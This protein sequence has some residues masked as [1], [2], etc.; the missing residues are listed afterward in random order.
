[1]NF[2][3]PATVPSL[4]RNGN[5]RLRAWQIKKTQILHPPSATVSSLSSPQEA[6]RLG[7]RIARQLEH[8]QHIT[9]PG[10][11]SGRISEPGEIDYYRFTISE[12]TSLGPWWVIFPFDNIDETGFDTVYPPETEINLDKEYIGKDRRKIGWY[13]TDRRGE[14]V[15]SKRP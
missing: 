3:H 14:N 10:A 7:E 15:F 9:T 1:M 6:R 2:G 8:A 5:E 12:G 4:P 11:I 13:K